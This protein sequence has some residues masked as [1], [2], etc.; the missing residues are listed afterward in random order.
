MVDDA[1]VFELCPLVNSKGRFGCFHR[2]S[3]QSTINAHSK[4]ASLERESVFI[5]GRVPSLHQRTLFLLQ[6]VAQLS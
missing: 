3:I 4:S 2:R 6:L 5:D 1:V